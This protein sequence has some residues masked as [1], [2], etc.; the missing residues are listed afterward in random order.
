MGGA[1]LA[2]ACLQLGGF[3]AVAA[4]RCT[5]ALPPALPAACAPLPQVPPAPGAASL[6]E[7]YLQAAVKAANED[8]CGSLSCSILVHPATE[9]A[10]GAAV[11]RALDELRFG[12]VAVNA[13][14]SIGFLPAQVGVM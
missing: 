6:E 4:E 1:G 9:A 8:V 2:D 7:G 10:H 14:S 11:Q 12:S 5:D 13:W 3:L